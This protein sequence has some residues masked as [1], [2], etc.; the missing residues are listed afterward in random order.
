MLDPCQV[1]CLTEDPNDMELIETALQEN[2]LLPDRIKHQKQKAKALDVFC[3][4]R[5]T[6]DY[7]DFDPDLAGKKLSEN[8]V[9][10]CRE[11]N[12]LSDESRVIVWNWPFDVK[13]EVMIP[14]KHILMVK[15]DS[16]FR[17][18]LMAKDRTLAHEESQ[19]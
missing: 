12:P 13:R 11:M 1:L 8:P 17:S 15:A 19:A 5:G 7:G 10:F 4:Y 2:I 9:G 18:C 3:F 6:G 16:A 14:P